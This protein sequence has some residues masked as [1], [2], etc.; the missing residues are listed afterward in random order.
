MEK[1]AVILR[2]YSEEVEYSKEVEIR[3]L[4]DVD[5]KCTYI[6]SGLKKFS[7]PRELDNETIQ[8]C[9]KDSEG[10]LQPFIKWVYFHDEYGDNSKFEWDENIKTTISEFFLINYGRKSMNERPKYDIKNTED[11]MRI[12]TTCNIDGTNLI[13]WQTLEN[14]FTAPIDAAENIFKQKYWDL[15]EKYWWIKLAG[16]NHQFVSFNKF[17]YVKDI[18]FQIMLKFF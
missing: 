17:H 10:N 13:E 1:F 4:K 5:Y 9:L 8:L 18:F 6:R 15:L 14:G 12:H 16:S 3:R 7:V 11:L 2:F